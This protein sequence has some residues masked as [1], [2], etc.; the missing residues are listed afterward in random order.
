MKDMVRKWHIKANNDLQ[1]GSHEMEYDRPATDTVCFHAQQAA[2]KYLKSY[3]QWKGL[4]PART[5]LLDRLIRDCVDFD[6]RF[7]ELK[8]HHIGDLTT[9]AVES[10]YLDDF[11]IP[12]SEEAREALGKAL[13]TKQFVLERLAAAGYSD[14]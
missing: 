5:H 2:E 9:F 8:E 7:L 13:F 12:S 10:R 4:V 6:P 1:V 11:Y 3:L 14:I